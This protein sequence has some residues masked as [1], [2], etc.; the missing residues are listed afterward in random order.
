MASELNELIGALKITGRPSPKFDH[1]VQSE[2]VDS[3]RDLDQEADY[4]DSAFL[5]ARNIS[6]GSQK[7]PAKTGFNSMFSRTDSDKTKVGLLPLI[8]AAVDESE[9]M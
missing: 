2:K 7:L 1:P 9:T 8:N 6:C 5:F 4:K 3:D